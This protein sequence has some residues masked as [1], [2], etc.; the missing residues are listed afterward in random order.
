MFE[1]AEKN[2]QQ[3]LSFRH[4]HCPYFAAQVCVGAKLESVVDVLRVKIDLFRC[5]IWV[6]E[7]VHRNRA[8]LQEVSEFI[9]KCGIEG[10]AETRNCGSSNTNS[11]CSAVKV[12]LPPFSFAMS[13][14]IPRFAWQRSLG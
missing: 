5:F 8:K 11:I 13:R 10:S 9:R 4:E 14:N 12:S 6:T 7:L 1:V 2:S 3:R